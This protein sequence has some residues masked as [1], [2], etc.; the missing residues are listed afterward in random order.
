MLLK[1]QLL[2]LTG[3]VI[4]ASIIWVSCSSVE[5]HGSLDP[6]GPDGPFPL[7]RTGQ[8]TITSISP[9]GS[10]QAGVDTL[11]ITGTNFSTLLSDNTVYFNATPA[12]LLQATATQLT[13]GAPF[14]LG[15]TVNIRVAVKGSDLLSESFYYK[16]EAA[17]AAFGNLSKPDFSGAIATDASGNVFVEIT[18]GIADQAIWKFDTSGTSTT[19][20]P[21]TGAVVTWSCLR[22]GPSGY[23]Y[24][25]RT[26]RAIFRYEAAG[27]TAAAIWGTAFPTGV[28][29]TGM[30][31]DQNQNLWAV[32]NN[33]SVYRVKQDLSKASFPFTANLRACR[34]FNGHLYMAGQKDNAEKIWRAPIVG[35]SLGTP[36]VYFDFD[37]AYGAKGYIPQVLTFASDGTLYIGTNS[38]VGIVV[39]SPS[40]AA[41]TPVAA[42]TDQFADFVKYLAWGSGDALYISSSTGQLG[43]F[44]TRTAGAPNYGP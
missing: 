26:T 42:Y 16:L 24:A 36:E 1:K 8:P 9:A 7:V 20:A 5:E 37:A 27:G 2:L 23:L 33:T 35:D 40:G 34:V 4:A 6:T 15:D 14:V 28:Y 30:D 21:K 3:L 19:F 22:V 12:A 31:F 29:I 32:G 44:K 17:V 41:T 13:M 18:D 11:V 38:E 39:V 10:A 43:L 25:A